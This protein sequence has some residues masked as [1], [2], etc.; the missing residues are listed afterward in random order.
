[1]LNDSFYPLYTVCITAKG[2]PYVVKY[3][4]T[5]TTMLYVI[6]CFMSKCHIWDSNRY[7]YYNLSITAMSDRSRYNFYV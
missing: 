6:G 7:L 2:Y 5:P 3:P 1:M 4:T